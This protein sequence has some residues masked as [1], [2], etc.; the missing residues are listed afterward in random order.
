L[1]IDG[2]KFQYVDAKDAITADVQY[3]QADL[4][5]LAKEI[6]GKDDFELTRKDWLA[7]QAKDWTK[8]YGIPAIFIIVFFVIFAI[9]GR[10][11][12]GQVA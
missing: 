6:A 7:A 9:F 5:K 8:I 12:K 11:P 1:T 4:A 3:T 2:I 10:E